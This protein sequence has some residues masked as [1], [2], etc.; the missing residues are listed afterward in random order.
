MHL[1]SADLFAVQQRY[2]WELNEVTL[3]RKLFKLI[4]R[5][6]SSERMQSI[7]F[8]CRVSRDAFTLFVRLY[9]RKKGLHLTKDYNT[10]TIY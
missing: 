3:C 1:C 9:I 6:K 5:E 7:D 4:T 8:K 2:S 10:Y